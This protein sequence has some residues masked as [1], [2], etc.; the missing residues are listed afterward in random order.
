MCVVFI[1]VQPCAMGCEQK[2]KGVSTQVVLEGESMCTLVVGGG[3]W[4]VSGRGCV[5]GCCC[6]RAECLVAY[7]GLE[8][9]VS[10]VW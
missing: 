7:L 2:D 8:L 3:W 6:G 1:H 5:A 9:R 10:S 4:W